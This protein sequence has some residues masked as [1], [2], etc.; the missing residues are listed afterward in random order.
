MATSRSV[1][2][3]AGASGLGLAIAD[4]FAA[5]GDRVAICDIDADAVRKV[6][7][8]HRAITATVCDVRD[9]SAVA[10]FVGEVAG[11]AGGIDVVV[12]NAGIAG[13]TVPVEELDPDQWDAVMAVNLTGA[14][15]LMHSAVPHLKRSSCGVL[16]A[17]SSVA[18]RYGYPN[19]SAY[20][21]SKW[22]LVGLVKSL[23]VE[24]GDDGIRANAILPGGIE[25]PRLR[26]VLADRADQEGVPVERI[27]ERALAVQSIKQFVDP[28]E[29]AG[30]AVFL[31]SD[32]AR[33]ITGQQISIDNDAKIP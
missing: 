6:A 12:S 3:T 31:A 20:A 26:R 19:R 23:A 32:A 10:H 1:L 22:G 21:A 14:F 7:T 13:P 4:A 8:R 5:V 30:L 9:R 28:D 33:S 24:L 29:V 27:V 25:G 11:R 16:L 18:G 15:N 17:I 2:V